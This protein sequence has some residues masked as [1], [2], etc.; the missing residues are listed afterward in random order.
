[1]I[2]LLKTYAIATACSFV[3]FFT[4]CWVFSKRIYRYEPDEDTK[5]EPKIQTMMRLITYMFIPVLR[6]IFIIGLLFIIAAPDDWVDEY[7]EDVE[8]KR[9]NRYGN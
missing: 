1:M 2:T 6:V 4:P 8:S 9:R 3:L 5:R 7:N